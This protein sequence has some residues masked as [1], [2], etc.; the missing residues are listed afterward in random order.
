M[1]AWFLASN[2]CILAATSVTAKSTA[3]S[4]CPMHAQK[5]HPQ[6]REKNKGCGDL[7]CCK[8]LQATAS[9]LTKTIAKPI[10]PGG[11]VAFL[12]PG[13]TATEARAQRL[14]P[15]L[16]TGPPGENN[17]TQLVLQRSILAHAPPA[18]LS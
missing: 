6:Q 17:F 7:P 14:S 1:A 10:W 15:I 11:L 5:Q 18:S 12:S 2:H 9:A 8:T 4:Q 13:I 16:D 3:P